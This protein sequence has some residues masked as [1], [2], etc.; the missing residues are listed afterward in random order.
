[1]FDAIALAKKAKQE[2]EEVKKKPLI[3]RFGKALWKF[4]ISNRA[5]FLF[6]EDSFVRR[7]ASAFIVWVLLKRN[8]YT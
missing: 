1:M 8:M 3:I 6:T 2:E 4:I 5:L 7:F